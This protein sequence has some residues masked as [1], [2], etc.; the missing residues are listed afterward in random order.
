MI[1]KYEA[2]VSADSQ[3]QDENDDSGP[4]LAS[5]DNTNENVKRRIRHTKQAVSSDSNLDIEDLSRDDLV[6]LVAEKE[7]LLKIKDYEFQK[8]KKKV[9]I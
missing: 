9:V 1:W 7:E 5:K 4:N 3:G 2:S 8:M 6:K